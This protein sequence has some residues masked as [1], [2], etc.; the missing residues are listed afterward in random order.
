MIHDTAQIL[1]IPS[2]LKDI[3]TLKVPQT[4]E[5]YNYSWIEKENEILIEVKCDNG[6]VILLLAKPK[7]EKNK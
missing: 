1:E 6:I 2:V 3:W 7:L 5:E 4:S